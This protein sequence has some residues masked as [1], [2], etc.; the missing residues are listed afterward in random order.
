MKV[1]IIIANRDGMPFLPEAV[2]SALRQTFENIH[3]CVV[4]GESDD[5]SVEYLSTVSDERLSWMSSPR[6]WGP[7]ARRNLGASRTTG[8]YMLFLDSDD[9]LE[10]SAVGD[11]MALLDGSANQLAVGGLLRF[12]H[13]IE[14]VHDRQTQEIEYSPAVGNV[15][16]ARTTFERVGR[17]N[18]S[19]KV[20]DFV[21]WMSRARRMNVIEQT[22]K[23]LV[24]RRREHENNL[25]RRLR[26]EYQT[27]YLNLIRQHLRT[28]QNSGSSSDSSGL[29]GIS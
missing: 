29:R 14:P 28:E 11:L 20:G 25:S 23:H 13:G 12:F 27:D 5:G 22:T 17:F 4:D 7:A 18:E 19:L 2:E 16:L 6:E 10:Q 21:E 3:L 1:D 26:H 9:T 24:L 8:D 15:L